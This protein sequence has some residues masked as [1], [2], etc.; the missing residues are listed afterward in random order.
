MMQQPF[1]ENVLPIT[2]ARDKEPLMQSHTSETA[3]RIGIDLGGT[4]IEGVVLDGPRHQPEV[5]LRRRV[6]TEPD[7]GYLHIAEQVTELIRALAAGCDIPLPCPIGVGMPGSVTRQGLVKNSNTTCL[8][9]TPF[10]QEIEALL[11]QPVAFANDANCFAL[12]EATMGAARGH[13]VVFGV[14]MG[15]G[16]GGGIVIDGRIHEGPQS[17]AGEWGHMV[18]RPD[19]DRQCYCGQAGCVETYLAGPWVERHYHQVS[20]DNMKLPTIVDRWRDGD[21]AATTCVDTWLDHYGRAVANL[22]NV[23]DPD[24]IVLGG[25]VSNADCLYEEGRARI[26]PY[27]FSD[28]LLTPILQHTLG[29][30]AG[31]FG[32]AMLQ[33]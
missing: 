16:V 9:G 29:D 2:G 27:L 26:A 11:G 32:A 22:I 23:L 20:G 10:R 15:T 7:H 33:V 12:A 24:A 25:G 17:I 28:E 31:V 3:P 19:S 13:A 5:R 18:L 4:K 14:I 21:A 30:S 6:A 8:N 1:G